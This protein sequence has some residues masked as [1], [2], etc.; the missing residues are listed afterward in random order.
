[1]ARATFSGIK[2]AGQEPGLGEAAA[3]QNLPVERRAMAA[4]TRRALRRL[5]V[6]HQH[7][8]DVSYAARRGEIGR[9][10]HRQRLDDRHAE[11]RADVGGARRRS[12]CHAAAGNRASPPA[13]TA[14]AASSSG[15][16]IS[17]TIFSRPRMRV[18]QRRAPAPA[19]TIARRLWDETP[20]RH[21][22]R[23]RAPPHRRRRRW[24]IP[25]ILTGDGH[26]MGLMGR[27]C[28]E[29]KQTRNRRLSRQEMPRLSA[30]SR[31]ALAGSGA[32]V[33]G[34][35][36][37][38]MLGARARAPRPGPSPGCWSPTSAPGGPDAR[39]HQQEVRPQLG[40]QRARSH[41]PN[42]PRHPARIAGSARASRSTWSPTGGV[43]PT[44]GRSSSPGW[45]AR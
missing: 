11:A 16:A 29:I 3:R 36:I 28:P 9:F 19:S 41:A 5:G 39:H 2:P 17:A 18:R 24:L 4:G 14:P 31:A 40:A 34:R 27:A 44:A 22:R 26:G 12:P 38:R 23:R 45:S 43:R 1:M 6:E 21:N 20:A 33:M 37:T 15:S 30:I 32:A 42:T 13:I 8:G 25:Q 10:G 7:V 35:P